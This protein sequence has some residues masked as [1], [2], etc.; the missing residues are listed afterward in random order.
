MGTA[1]ISPVGSFEAGSFESFT[2][3]YTAGYFGI[4]DTGSIKIVHRFASD[5]GRPQ[6][7][8]PQAANYTTVEASNGAVL[9]V[10]Y[11]PKLNIRPWDKTLMIRVMRGF[12]REGDTITVRL[13][14][15]RQGSPGIRVQTFVEP[16]FEFKVLVD[17]FA[18]YN[19]VEL[20]RQPTIPVVSGPPVGYKAILP[21][22]RRAGQ[23]F[24]FGFKGED[25][26]G[27]P[28][29]QVA[30]R[31]QLE[32]SV[33]VHGLPSVLEVKKGTPATALRNLKVDQPGEL[34][35]TVRDEAGHVV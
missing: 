21:S 11:D 7:S 12:L 13:G 26:W 8:G 17:A 16:T 2:L 31:F 28:S 32:A 20:P 23:A 9:N 1:E 22:Q 33:P 4:D 30:G 6:W 35:I 14:D 19:F 27:N 25:N 10:L 34:R 29:D 5:M 15:T 3:V 18:T 24:T